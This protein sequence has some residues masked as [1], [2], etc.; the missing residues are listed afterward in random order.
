MELLGADAEK[1]LSTAD[2]EQL[3]R[4]IRQLDRRASQELAGRVRSCA[5]CGARIGSSVVGSVYCCAWHS[6][7][8]K[9]NPSGA[10]DR[11][12]FERK[13]AMRRIRKARG[14]TAQRLASIEDLQ[15]PGYA[16]L[17]L[18]SRDVRVRKILSEYTAITGR[19][20]SR[21]AKPGGTVAAPGGQRPR[22]A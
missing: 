18:L 16:H 8:D 21:R 15:S 9:G 5:Y 1:T 7:V 17:E 22:D 14:L 3:R 20:L 19:R 11:I 6:H 13:R 10:A 4:Q 12:E 2:L